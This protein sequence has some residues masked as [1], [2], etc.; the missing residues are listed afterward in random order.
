MI[1]KID[2]FDEELN[3]F[4]LDWPRLN[5][6]RKVIRRTRAQRN[7]NPLQPVMEEPHMIEDDDMFVDSPPRV[8]KAEGVHTG[9]GKLQR[10]S[11]S[12]MAPS[13]QNMMR[14]SDMDPRYNPTPNKPDKKRM[15]DDDGVPI[16]TA[17]V[18][19]PHEQYF[20]RGGAGANYQVWPAIQSEDLRRNLELGLTEGQR[21][22]NGEAWYKHPLTYGEQYVQ[23]LSKNHD[24]KQKAE[25]A[26]EMGGL[27]AGGVA[28]LSMSEVLPGSPAVIAAMSSGIRQAFPGIAL[29][30]HVLNLMA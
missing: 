1:L 8:S 15:L 23:Q 13:R 22:K 20:A 25:H 10:M 3:P 27:V 6:H 26:L 17:Q 12:P 9:G 11:A 16:V 29:D 18:I 21:L 24:W 14:G 28:A 5:L 4:E 30:P 2:Y 19:D 7:N